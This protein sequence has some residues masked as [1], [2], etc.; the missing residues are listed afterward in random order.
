MEENKY[1]VRFPEEKR[2]DCKVIGPLSTFHVG[3]DLHREVHHYRVK[4][5]EAYLWKIIIQN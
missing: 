5:R 4:G 2:F 3:G 1:M